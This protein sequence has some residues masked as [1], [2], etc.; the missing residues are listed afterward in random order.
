MYFQH[1]GA[2][3]HD[4][5]VFAAILNELYPERL[6]GANAPTFWPAQSPDLTTIDFYLGTCNNFFITCTH[7]NL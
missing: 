4:E 7:K 6:I 5:G 1:D 2:P 3:A